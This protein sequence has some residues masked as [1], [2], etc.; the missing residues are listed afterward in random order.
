MIYAA[1]THV[2]NVRSMNQDA[3]L[4][5]RKKD[6]DV[7]VVAVADGMGGHKAGNIASVMALEAVRNFSD[8][9]A[10]LD[11]TLCSLGASAWAP[12][13]PWRMCMRRISPL[14]TWATAASIF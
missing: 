12:R 4:T 1:D 7:L 11:E 9:N 2:G 8:E 14:L 5:F 13:C 3:F 10:Q 6:T